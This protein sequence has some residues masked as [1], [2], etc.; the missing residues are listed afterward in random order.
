MCAMAGM[1]G[2][3]DNFWELPGFELKSLHLQSKKAMP[4]IKVILEK[5]RGGG[6]QHSITDGDKLGIPSPH[7]HIAIDN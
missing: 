6:F 2:R 3:G 4:E 7:P 5:K 1:Q